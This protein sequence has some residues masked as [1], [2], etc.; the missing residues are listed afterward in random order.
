MDT[1][2]E[3]MRALAQ[4]DKEKLTVLFDHIAPWMT[5]G[6]TQLQTTYFNAEAAYLLD[7]REQAKTLF[8]TVEEQGK[9]T[10]LCDRAKEYLRKIDET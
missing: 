5:S 4:K 6:F 9:E 2:L 7:H 10:F 8:Q 3:L 1:T